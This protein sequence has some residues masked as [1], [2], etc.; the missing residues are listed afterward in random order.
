MPTG[1]GSYGGDGDG[2]VVAAPSAPNAVVTAVAENAAARRLLRIGLL[3]DGPVQPAW[4]ERVLREL[5][6]DAIGEIA[7]V[8]INE[9]HAKPATEA[10]APRRDL[11]ARA[12]RWW[13]NR[14]RLPYALYERIDSRRYSAGA[15]SAHK[16]VDLTPMLHGV[17]ALRVRPR[18]TRFC[19]YLE[20]SDVASIRAHDLDV[21][22]R[23][24]FRILKGEVLGS[25]RDGVWSFHHGDNR[26]NRGGPA[27][28]WEVVLNQRTTGATLQRLTEELDGGS[29]I[30]R[31][32][33]S[34]NPISATANRENFYWQGAA[35][36]VAHL[37]RLRA[38]TVEPAEEQGWEAYSRPLYVAPRPGEVARLAVRVARRLVARKLSTMIRREQWTL[39]YRMAPENVARLDVPDGVMYRYRELRPPQ[40]RYWAD[41]FPVEH[42]GRYWLFYEEHMFGEPAAHI[43]VVEIDAHGLPGAHATVLERD[44][45]LSYP[46]VFRWRDEW[47][48]TPETAALGKV[49]LFR[50]TRFPD[51]WEH[52][53]DLLD[54]VVATDPTLVEVDGRWWMFVGRVVPGATEASALHLYH[55]PSPLGPWRPHAQNPVKIDVSRARPAGRLFRLD[56]Q[57]YRPAQ[58]G[59]PTYGTAVVV[60]RIDVLTPDRF[61]E[62]EVARI[63]ATWR[64]GIVGTHT[65]NA[66]GRLSA[67]DARR[68][69]PMLLGSIV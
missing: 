55:A 37:R 15:A 2:R 56:G 64:P 4:V 62:C 3:V 39:F 20:A 10:G 32:E 8:V 23:L 6:G 1:V 33:V 47:W 41:P 50:A 9:T 66:A 40:D 22:L 31:I 26:V 51:Q 17:P 48:M 14:A 29:V 5:T 67:T 35:L 36:L 43:N 45:H 44:H 12:R 18:M 59:A 42:E 16:A 28:L 61:R 46:S 24:G 21:I 30:A 52:A 25:A 69:R 13:D 19:D 60:H 58:D 63:D 49:Q 65:L 54:D 34:T 11:L 7:L 57:L 68:R 53:A 27:G 38:G